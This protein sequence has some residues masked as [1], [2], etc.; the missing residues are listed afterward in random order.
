MRSIV[1]WIKKKCDSYLYGDLL[2]P[3][4]HCHGCG[5]KLLSGEGSEQVSGKFHAR[6][7]IVTKEISSNG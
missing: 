4:K 2:L 1:F 5:E 6:C 7:V 3:P